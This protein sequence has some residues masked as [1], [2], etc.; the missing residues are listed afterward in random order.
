M[1][2]KNTQKE[3]NLPGTKKDLLIFLEEWQWYTTIVPQGLTRLNY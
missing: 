1:S 3:T 2:R